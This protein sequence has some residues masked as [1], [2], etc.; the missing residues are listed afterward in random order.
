MHQVLAPLRRR[1]GQ[2]SSVAARATAS[3]VMAANAA[4]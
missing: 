3:M 2:R 4:P 1:A